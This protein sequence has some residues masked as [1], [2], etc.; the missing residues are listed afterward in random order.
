MKFL[1]V[2][3]WATWCEP[4]QEEF[5]DLEDMARMYQKRPFELVTVSIN[6]P[7]DEYIGV[8]SISGSARLK[9]R[10]APGSSGAASARRRRGGGRGR[11]P[12]DGDRFHEFGAGAVR[13]VKVELAF[14]VDSDPDFERL[15]VL[16]A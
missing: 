16:P 12:V 13:V 2:N 10:R 6:Y 7:D 15:A 14:A 3:F 11:F 4:C 8:R 9:R 5:P 1:V